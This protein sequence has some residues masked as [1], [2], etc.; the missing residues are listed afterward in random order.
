VGR[1]TEQTGI[2]RALSD[3]NAN[4]NRRIVGFFRPKRSFFIKF[5]N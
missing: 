1:Q 4:K 3:L 5:L 2:A